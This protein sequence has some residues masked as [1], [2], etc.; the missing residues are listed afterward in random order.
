MLERSACDHYPWGHSSTL[1]L[2]QLLW[3]AW[4]ESAGDRQ[5][6]NIDPGKEAR[7]PNPALTSFGK[8]GGL[9]GWGGEGLCLSIF[10]SRDG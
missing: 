4:E 8:V 3:P 2:W 9:W 1:A 5:H 7:R 6:V 10:L